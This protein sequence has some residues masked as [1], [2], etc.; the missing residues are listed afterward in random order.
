LIDVLPAQA[1]AATAG[2]FPVSLAAGCEAIELAESLGMPELATSPRSAI[3][4]DAA[5]IGD[6]ERCEQAAA[7]L[8]DDADPE[9]RRSAR[10]AS[11]WLALNEG[12]LD[13]ACELYDIGRRLRH[14]RG[15][16]RWETEWVEAL[17]TGGA[18]TTA[19]RCSTE[20]VDDGWPAALAPPSTMRATGFVRADEEAAYR[21]SNARSAS[22]SRP[23]TRSPRPAAGW[24]GA[25][26][27]RR[28]AGAP[29][30]AASS[31]GPTRCSWRWAPTPTPIAPPRRLAPPAPSRR[32]RSSPHRLL[33]PHEL[34]IAR[35]VVGGGAR[36]ATSPPSC[37]SRRGRS[38]PTLDD[39]PQARRP[40][41]PRAVSARPRRTRSSARDVG[42]LSA[43][44]V[45]GDRRVH[46]YGPEAGATSRPARRAV[47]TAGRRA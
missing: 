7:V 13:D 30:R 21:T 11:A 33:T 34:Q 29:T 18:A 8:A 46:G 36:P 28:V 26:Q 10:W 47:A 24:R 41:P 6:R 35:L 4:L 22:A 27:L 43:P 37:S 45:T 31:I 15:V 23:G 25:K 1:M 5:V 42:Q 32:T 40:Q 14:R 19:R 3:G 16:I 12:R 44:L 20:L 2:R 38:K 9:T 39:L 17:A